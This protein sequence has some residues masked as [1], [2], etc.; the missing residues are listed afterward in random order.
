MKILALDIGAGTEDI[1]LF[2]DRKGSLEN[3]VKMVLPSPTNI[4]ASKVKEANNR[5]KDVFLTGDTIGGGPLSRA[6][7]RHLQKGLKVFAHEKTAFTIRNDLN[8]VRELGI[9]IIPENQEPKNFDGVKLRLEEINLLKLE[10]FLKDFDESLVGVDFVAIGVQDHGISNKGMSNRQSRIQNMKTLLKEEPLPE[11][12]AFKEGEIPPFFLR[13]QSAAQAS[14]R[15]LP[16]AQVL[17][18]DTAPAALLGCLKDPVVEKKDRV[19]AVNIGNGHT[20]FAIISKGKIQGL[21]EHHTCLLDP[22]KLEHLVVR[23]ADGEIRNKDV[24]REG[25]HGLFYL[26]EPPGFSQI[27]VVAVTGPNRKMASKTDF[28]SYFAVPG[29]DMMMTGPIG[30]IEATNRLFV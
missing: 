17:L 18:M 21:M 8:E 12:L 27:D 13:M 23:L 29:G 19:V 10:N 14:R 1:L 22:K 16:E 7:R 6:I 4:Y 26:T 15:Q 5:N 24:F 25:G 2:D 30:L 3:C 20:M 11:K 9:E 28:S